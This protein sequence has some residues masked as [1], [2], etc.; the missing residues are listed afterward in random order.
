MGTLYVVGTPIGNLEDLTFRAA[1][2][3]GEVDLIAAEDTRVTRKL[4][5]HLGLKVPLVSYHEH[6]QVART[7]RI[8]AALES[9]DVALA[10]DAGMPVISDP[11]AD[12]VSQA[13]AAGFQVVVIPGA[14]AVTTALAASGC[15]A[16]AFVFLGFLPRRGK[17][18]RGRLELARS[19]LLTLVLFE[20][21]H[22]L[23]ATL[24]DL[25]SVL[26]DRQ[27]AVCRELTK[28]YEEVFRGTI[29]EALEHFQSPRGEFVLVIEGPSTEKGEASL[30]L[31]TAAAAVSNLE[32]AQEQLAHLKQSG[33]HAKEAVSTV[34]NLLKLPKKTVYH[35]WLQLPRPD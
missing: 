6:N 7:T 27:L 31:T 4:L 35:L 30:P 33:V 24:T 12:L 28:V 14:S 26:G 11:G 18:R 20:S 22:H 2:V 3:F 9:G 25:R 15:P 17:E 23:G 5:N 10:T 1:R 29:T 16:D 8:L 19:S 32:A 21:P 13:A 34:A